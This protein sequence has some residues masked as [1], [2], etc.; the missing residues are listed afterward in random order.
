MRTT[1]ETSEALAASLRLPVATLALPRV[2][3][4]VPAWLRVG[5]AIVAK[6]HLTALVVA[7]LETKCAKKYLEGADEKEFFV[8]NKAF[9]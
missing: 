1:S 4:A 7:N 8:V 5:A 2:N 9:V 6:G 3:Y